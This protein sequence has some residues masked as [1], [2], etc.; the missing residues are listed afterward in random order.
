MR[1]N[2]DESAG[3]AVIRLYLLVIQIYSDNLIPK[4]PNTA[5][6]CSRHG[7]AMLYLFQKHPFCWEYEYIVYH[8]EITYAKV[9]FYVFY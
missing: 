4:L 7:Q 2:E 5:H 8:K 1:G 3:I 6:S 9:K